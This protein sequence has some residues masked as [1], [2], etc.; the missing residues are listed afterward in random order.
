MPLA[1]NIMKYYGFTYN[2][3]DLPQDNVWKSIV[4]ITLKDN[5]VVYG[6]EGYTEIEETKGQ[7][8]TKKNFIKWR[9]ENGLLTQIE[10]PTE[11]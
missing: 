2:Q 10:L 1:T 4:E 7:T 3:N 9:E 6:Y 8:F 11:E 5:T